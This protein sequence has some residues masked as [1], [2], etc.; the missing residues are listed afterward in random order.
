MPPNEEAERL[1]FCQR[2]S[3]FN[4]VPLLLNSLLLF[5]NSIAQMSGFFKY[6]FPYS[7]SLKPLLQGHNEFFVPSSE[8]GEKI[9]YKPPPPGLYPPLGTRNA[10]WTTALARIRSFSEMSFNPWMD[11]AWLTAV[12]NTSSAVSPHAS[13]SHSVPKSLHLKSF[14]MFPLLLPETTGRTRATL[15]LR[16]KINHFSSRRQGADRSRRTLSK[17]SLTHLEARRGK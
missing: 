7:L 9:Q 8:T 10:S 6:F 3:L 16:P 15:F 14:S 12:S 1:A 2:A 13:K 17:L 5:L 4:L 11:R